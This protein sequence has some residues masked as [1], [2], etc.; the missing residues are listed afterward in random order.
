M[1]H[2]S[3]IKEGIKLF[4]RKKKKRN[5]VL[6]HATTRMDPEDIMLSE[7]S[8]TQKGQILYNASSLK[9]LEIDKFIGT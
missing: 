3:A 9:Y 1:V 2:H 8:Q 7:K 6:T 4:T 5:E